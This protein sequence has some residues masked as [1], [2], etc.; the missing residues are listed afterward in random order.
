MKK[1]KSVLFACLLLLLFGC[2]AEDQ[3]ATDE[4]IQ[5]DVCY[6]SISATQSVAMYAFEKGIYEEYDLDVN[7]VF[8]EGGSTATSAMIAGEMDICQIAGSAVVNGVVGGADIKIIAGL[9]NTYVYSLMVT[10][11]I[12]SADDLVGKALAVSS[13]GGS[14]DTAMR[15]VVESLGLV[16]D[17]D[18]AIISVGGQSKRLAAM[19]SGAAAGTVVSVPQTAQARELGYQELVNMADLNVP[20]QHTALVTSEA[21]L[22]ENPETVE[23]F[24]MA[25]I[26]AIGQMKQDKEGVIEVLA[27]Y[28]LLDVEEER[29]VLEEAVDVLILGYL[30]D[31]PRPTESGIQLQLDA[32]ET[33]NSDAVNFSPADILDTTILTSIEDSDFLDSLE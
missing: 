30:P 5:I 17:G 1:L 18:V 29:A 23:R 14:S 22:N 13:F 15:A 2:S 4:V 27:Q 16:P 6:S 9:F 3:S 19:E 12:A 26:D 25:T 21:L 33:E 10:P 11:E 20:F 7:L 8:I 24:L 32:L 31:V 28:L